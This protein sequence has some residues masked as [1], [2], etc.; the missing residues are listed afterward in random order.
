MGLF[1]SSPSRKNTK[2][3]RLRKI[4]AKI[5]KLEKRKKLDDDLKKAETRLKQLSK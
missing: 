2:A 1:G 5:K 3:A 4:N